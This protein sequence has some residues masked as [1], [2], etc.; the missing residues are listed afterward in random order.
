M[1]CVPTG[2][3]AGPLMTDVVRA[4]HQLDRVVRACMRANHKGEQ[5]TCGTDTHIKQITRSNT[6]RPLLITLSLIERE[7]KGRLDRSIDQTAGVWICGLQ[8]AIRERG[9]PAR[10]ALLLIPGRQNGQRST[11]TSARRHACRCSSRGLCFLCC[12]W[13]M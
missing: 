11:V 1:A 10:L 6:D 2:S 12:L 9:R 7:R 3:K 13:L 5:Q 4:M 8:I